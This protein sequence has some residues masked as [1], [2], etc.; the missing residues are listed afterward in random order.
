MELLGDRY[1]PRVLCLLVLE[2]LAHD[3]WRGDNLLIHF[4]M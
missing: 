2:E 3:N 4:W 1:E